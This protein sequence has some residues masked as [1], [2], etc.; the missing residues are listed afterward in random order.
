M[1]QCKVQN[2]AH[3]G[4]EYTLYICTR[5]YNYSQT[6]VKVDSAKTVGQQTYIMYLLFNSPMAFNIL[7]IIIF[8]RPFDI[9]L[10]LYKFYLSILYKVHTYP[11]IAKYR[12]TRIPSQLRYYT[13]LRTGACADLICSVGSRIYLRM[14]IKSFRTPRSY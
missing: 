11:F 10:S 2:N 1:K 4:S 8:S 12:R 5:T 7:I 13:P 14:R 3:R 6:S 9:P